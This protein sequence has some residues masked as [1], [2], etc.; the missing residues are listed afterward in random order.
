M[1]KISIKEVAGHIDQQVKI[2]GFV[3]TIRDQKNIKFFLVRDIS[4]VIQIVITK[5]K[6]EA[7]KSSSGLSLESVVEITGLAKEEKQAPGGLE[8]A[9]EDISTLSLSDPELPIPVIEKGQQE[10]TDQSIRLDW[11]WIDLR[12]E[13]NTLVF[14]V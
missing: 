1:E 4:G 2:T 6:E 9:V 13:K 8:I 11:R 3:Q 14:K 5:D 12:K 10:E 7:F